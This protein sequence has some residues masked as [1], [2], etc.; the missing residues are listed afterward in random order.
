M[1]LKEAKATGVKSV[2]VIHGTGVVKRVVQEFLKHYE[3][4]VFYR[5]GYPREGGS[6][7]SIVFPIRK[8]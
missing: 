7:V 5:E 1:F 3:K 6:E 4:V 8:S 2:K